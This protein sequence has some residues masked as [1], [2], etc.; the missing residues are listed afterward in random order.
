MTPEEAYEMTE[1]KWKAIAGGDL[2]TNPSQMTNCG[3]CLFAREMAGTPFLKIKCNMSHCPVPA[4]FGNYCYFL[5]WLQDCIS[6]YEDPPGFDY[7]DLA[8][9]VLAQLVSHKEQ[10]IREMEKIRGEKR[11]R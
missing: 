3:L 6:V 5:D 11:S 9:V 2:M 7:L 8:Q 4:V 10:L 1:R